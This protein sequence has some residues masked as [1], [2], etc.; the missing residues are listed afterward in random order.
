[1]KS[2]CLNTGGYRIKLEAV[3]G[4]PD[5][6]P[7]ARFQK[8]ITDGN[9]YDFL[10]KVHRGSYAIPDK[11]RR[12]FRA[13]WQENNVDR[14]LITTGELWSI[15]TNGDTLYLKVF[16]PYDED[17]KT[18]TLVFSLKSFPWHLWIETED[19]SFDPL[20]YPLDGLLLYYLTVINGDIMIHASG[21][22]YAGRGYVFSGISGKGKT[23]IAH[24]WEDEGAGVIHDDRLIIRRSG[25][26]YFFY[27]TPVYENDEPRESR[28]DKMFLIEH[29]KENMIVPVSGSSAVSQ[30]LAN[31]I[32]H[33][34]NM[35]II[36]GSIKAVSLMCESI[37]VAK[38][39]FKPDRNIVD[40]IKK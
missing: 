8:Y 11:A 27:N 15:F 36:A 3:P 4:G 40:F 17:L 33:N 25:D 23:T 24:L 34:W 5:F 2:Y 16:F 1:M 7:S 10:I 9:S 32:Q 14:T 12:V 26:K 20:S 19:N 21:V 29:G 28:L 22:N 6:L 30:V 35:E 37:P 18:G 39:Y 38:L 31:C 13:P